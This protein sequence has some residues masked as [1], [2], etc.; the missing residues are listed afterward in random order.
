M[1]ELG[2]FKAVDST[3]AVREYV[4]D[5]LASYDLSHVL[6]M[7]QMA[8]LR[9]TPIEALSW[10]GVIH[11]FRKIYLGTL[12]LNVDIDAEHGARLV[13]EGAGD[14][15]AFGRAY[16]ANPDLVERIASGSRLNE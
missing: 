16:I 9:G 5:R 8:D 11:H 1:N 6:L 13:S 14:L 4:Y 10:D 7:R 2:V 15:V 3:L 12:I